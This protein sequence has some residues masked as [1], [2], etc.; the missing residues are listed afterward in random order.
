MTFS[1]FEE[2]AARFAHAHPRLRNGMRRFFRGW[3]DVRLR[4][5]AG[6]HSARHWRITRTTQYLADGQF[7]G[8]AAVTIGGQPRGGRLYAVHRPSTMTL[9]A[10]A[11]EHGAGPDGGF[12]ITE[13]AL[14][15]PGGQLDPLALYAAVV[16][17]E[18]LHDVASKLR[19]RKPGSTDLWLRHGCHGVGHDELRA[20]G[21]MHRGFA[22]P[23]WFKPDT[24]DPVQW[25]RSRS[26]RLALGRGQR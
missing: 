25:V 20:L 5:G 4:A 6:S 10:A 8:A 12:L 17:L 22:S 24:A 21:F 3:E 23:G 26:A 9:A 14:A 2:W 1:A 15:R 7:D 11:F 16:L 18:R 13:L 19:L